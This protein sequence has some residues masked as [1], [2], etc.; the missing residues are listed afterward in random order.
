MTVKDDALD[1]IAEAL[2]HAAPTRLAAPETS[3]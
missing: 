2:I 3:G 1:R